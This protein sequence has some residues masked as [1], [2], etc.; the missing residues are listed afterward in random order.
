MAIKVTMPTETK[1]PEKS[2]VL[3]W[4]SGTCGSIDGAI[5]VRIDDGAIRVSS[6]GLCSYSIRDLREF[7][8]EAILDPDLS[9]ELIFTKEK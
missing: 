9:L 7:G 3:T 8:N 2:L 6:G 4:R 5:W 1:A